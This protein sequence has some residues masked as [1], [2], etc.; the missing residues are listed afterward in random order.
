RHG[1]ALAANTDIRVAVA[2]IEKARAVLRGAKANQLPQASLGAGAN[3][4]RLPAAQ[5]LP[6]AP[7]EDWQVDAGL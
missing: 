2:R 7:R 6:G 3:Y 1:D 4:G 5:R